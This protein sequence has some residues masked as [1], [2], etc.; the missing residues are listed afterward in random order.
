MTFSG[1]GG[2]RGGQRS[3]GGGG[4]NQRH[5]EVSILFRSVFRK[6]YPPSNLP[7]LNTNAGRGRLIATGTGGGYHRGCRRSKGGGEWTQR[8]GEFFRSNLFF[9]NLLTI[10]FA[11][12]SKRRSGRRTMAGAEGGGRRVTGRRQLKGGGVGGRRRSRGSARRRGRR[13]NGR[14]TGRRTR[15]RMRGRMERRR[16]TRRDLGVF[17]T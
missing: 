16:R 17:S 1:G 10:K 13:W 2:R 12:S 9:N 7:L 11:A 6:I 14:R 3:K 4:P 15:G 5:F 8:S